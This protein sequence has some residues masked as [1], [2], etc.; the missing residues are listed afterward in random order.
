[1]VARKNL[2]SSF[3]ASPRR[4]RWVIDRLTRR[5]PACSQFSDVELHRARAVD[6]YGILSPVDQGDSEHIEVPLEAAID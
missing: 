4:S 5:T 6:F 3:R 1:M 2:S